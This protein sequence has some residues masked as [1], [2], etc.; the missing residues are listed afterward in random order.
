MGLTE[1]RRPFTFAGWVVA[2]SVARAALVGAIAVLVTLSGASAASGVEG[3]TGLREPLP[4]AVAVGANQFPNFSKLA[5]SPD[6]KLVAYAVENGSRLL[7]PR[8]STAILWTKSG[9]PAGYQGC[10]VWLTDLQ[11]GHTS[12]LTGGRGSSWAPNWSMGGERLAF[13]SD[14]DGRARVWTWD[15]RSQVLRRVSSA[16]THGP[17]AAEP[18]WADRDR[19]IFA[20]VVPSGMSLADANEYFN[21][22]LET[23][24]GQSEVSHSPVRVY[25]NDPTEPNHALKWARLQGYDGAHNGYAFD[26]GLISVGSGAVTRITRRSSAAEV[27][28]SDDQRYLLLQTQVGTAEDASNQALF[29]LS[30]LSL[31]GGAQRFVVR[32][33]PMDTNAAWQPHA[34][35]I[36]YTTGSRFPNMSTKLHGEIGQTYVVPVETGAPV[37]VSTG[38][39]PQF[40]MY[41]A[42]IVWNDAGTRLYHIQANQIWLNDVASK[43]V[44]QLPIPATLEVGSVLRTSAGRVFERENALFLIIRDGKTKKE[45]IAAVDIASG[46]VLAEHLSD[47]HVGAFR[48]ALIA[49]A[50][51]TGAIVFVAESS[52]KPQDLWVLDS[53]LK[54]ARQLTHLNPALERYAYGRAQVIHWKNWDGK[55]IGGTLIYPTGYVSGK[56]YPT[57]ICQYPS[58]L[59][60]NFVNIF[61]GFI[62][63]VDSNLQL[64]ATRGFAVFVPDFPTAGL[65]DSTNGHTLKW[66][67]TMLDFLISTGV[68]DPKRFGF[69]GASAGGFTGLALATQS[70]RL[71]AIIDDSGPPDYTAMF[72][73]FSPNGDAFYVKSNEELLGTPWKDR[74]RYIAMS[75]FYAFDRIT[76]P[77]M[78][79]QGGASTWVQQ[80][81][82]DETY[83][84]LRALDK[85]VQYV[86]YARGGHT[87]G[88][89]VYPDGVDFW[90]R[91]I[92]WYDRFLKG[93]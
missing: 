68:S 5:V 63:D 74:D 11:T 71:A 26:D 53:S 9:V 14:R 42:Q 72:S 70:D 80:K 86:L 78:I 79:M 6:G 19:A 1:L 93:H 75:P 54:H 33:V 91:S 8:L 45:G 81:E 12:N 55:T 76:T 32:N 27:L 51:R 40:G 28:V 92:A 46:R 7:E 22:Y 84:G 35:A 49:A 21:A 88:T 47:Q 64:Y 38:A 60:S 62:S 20:P 69:E 48:N 36:E 83:V 57:I 85:T 43:S 2:L 37:K 24:N 31:P 52:A 3:Q 4:V 58:Y 13:F 15:R 73:E 56:R 30:V 23:R 39:H 29:D 90:N 67:N 65:V 17:I 59:G 18:D 61:G 41:S 16:V 34:D 77:I 66:L 10:D 89:L 82:G 44:R 87:R 50:P 25:L